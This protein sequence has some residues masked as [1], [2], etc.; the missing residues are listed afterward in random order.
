ME[1][2]G[3]F[4]WHDALASRHLKD[5]LVGRLGPSGLTRHLL[6]R[7]TVMMGW[8]NLAQGPITDSLGLFRMTGHQCI[9]WREMLPW[10]KCGH[11]GSSGLQTQNAL[12]Y[13][14]A[15][16]LFVLF[17]FRVIGRQMA[18]WN[19]MKSWRMA[20]GVWAT[21]RRFVNRVSA[22]VLSWHTA[23]GHIRGAQADPGAICIDRISADGAGGWYWHYCPH[24]ALSKGQH[25]GN[26]GRCA[27]GD[28]SARMIK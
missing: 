3:I 2:A 9:S 4:H 23:Q 8:H 20:Y 26:L 14:A 24:Y 22:G 16:K 25:R 21:Q 18:W 13:G 28:L 6:A 12:A 10:P 11:G 19:A 7:Y 5:Y 17:K 1:I 15:Q 27:L